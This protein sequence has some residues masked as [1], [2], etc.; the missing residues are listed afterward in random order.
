MTATFAW[1]DSSLELYN[2]DS[3]SSLVD[4]DDT[5]LMESILSYS[6]AA[7]LFAIAVTAWRTM[8]YKLAGAELMQYL[9]SFGVAWA[10]THLLSDVNS[11]D[12]AVG[13][14]FHEARA[15]SYVLLGWG[16]MYTAIP[17]AIKDIVTPRVESLSSVASHALTLIGQVGPSVA[18]VTALTGSSHFAKDQLMHV[19][20]ALVAVVYGVHGVFYEAY[21]TTT[22]DKGMSRASVI[23][24]SVAATVAYIAFETNAEQASDPLFC[25][26][27]MPVAG[28]AFYLVGV[29]TQMRAG[30]KVSFV[31]GLPFLPALPNAN[32]PLPTSMKAIDSVTAAEKVVTAE[33]GHIGNLRP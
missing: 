30:A 6:S 22:N 15:M 23:S 17:M 27:A 31:L 7:L 28:L 9:W 20:L 29:D 25:A 10:T 11:V 12:D 1:I 4:S 26:L 24:T 3:N 21:K 8:S 32:L 18:T 19:P 2:D 33:L 13:G 16:C 14:H 5:T